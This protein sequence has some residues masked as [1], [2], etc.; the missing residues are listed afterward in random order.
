[1][2]TPRV[3][4]QWT[5]PEDIQVTSVQ[6][7]FQ[8]V[9]A[10]GW[11]DAGTVPVGLGEAFVSG[12]IAGQQYNFQIRSIRYT[13]ATSVWV[14][15]NAYTVSITLSTLGQVGLDPNALVGEAYSTSTAAIIVDPFTAVVG[16]FSESIL[17]AGAFTIATDGTIGGSAGSILPSKLYYVYYYDPAFAGGA[18]TPIATTN[19][20]DFTGPSKVGNFLIGSIVTPTYVSGGG[21][22]GGSIYRPSNDNDLGTRNTQNPE[23][24]FDGD[25]STC[26]TVS[27]S[28]TPQYSGGSYTGQTT[29]FGECLWEDF[30]AVTLGSAATLYVTLSAI[31]GTGSGTTGTIVITAFIAGSSVTLATLTA[32]TGSTTYTASVPSGTNISMVTLTVEV[33]CT[34]PSMQ[35]QGASAAVFEIWIQ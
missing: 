30:P 28:V 32:T 13:G 29:T 5:D 24:A 17:P 9:G 11:T 18:I 15:V 14:Q 19:P 21:G 33:T 34:A 6:V 3:L 20:A 25:T 1:V 27:A 23:F 10:S 2:I 7:Q 8:L 26:A 12:V 35:G 22:G 4:V 31:V 16:N